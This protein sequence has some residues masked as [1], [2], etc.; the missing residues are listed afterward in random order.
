MARN[1][2][3]S[4]EAQRDGTREEA[5]PGPRVR[6]ELDRRSLVTLGALAGGFVLLM[7]CGA[8]WSILYSPDYNYRTE[9][10]RAK[11]AT[12][13]NAV[14][15]YKKR[16]GDYP[17]SLKELTVGENGLPAYLEEKDIIDEWGVR[18]RY[19]P[20]D[21]TLESKPRIYTF[22]HEGKLVSNWGSN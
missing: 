17:S 8:F 14:M 6:I 11:I 5:R 13:E 1:T 19:D 7:A 15:D 9:V 2:A 3:M 20:W 16:H 12:I 4:E 18:I 22:D 21:L 10:T